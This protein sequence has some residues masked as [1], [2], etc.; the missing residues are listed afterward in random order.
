[1]IHQ[2]KESLNPQQPNRFSCSWLSFGVASV[3]FTAFL[4]LLLQVQFSLQTEST[5]LRREVASGKSLAKSVSDKLETQDSE[6]ILETDA[7]VSQLKL[8]VERLQNLIES[9]PKRY[10]AKT[11]AELVAQWQP[12][13]EE[14]Q[15][16]L[17]EKAKRIEFKKSRG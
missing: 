10:V 4:S 13:L 3:F 16:K 9:A 12:K 7:V 17:D 11:A 5:N 1:M 2:V 6:E 15:L 8:K 14:A